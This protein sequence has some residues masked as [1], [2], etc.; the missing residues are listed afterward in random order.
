MSI[1][2]PT[3]NKDHLEFYM[4]YGISPVRQNI[5]DIQKHLERRSSLYRKIGA[6]SILFKDK[7]VLEVGPGSGHNSLYVASC[8]PGRYDLLEPNKTAQMGIK[9]L[10]S[11]IKLDLIKPNL[12]KQKLEDFSTDIEYDIVICE[13]WL[14]V[15]AHEREMMKKLGELV[16]QGGIL[17]TTIASPLGSVSNG[18]R[19]VLSWDIVRNIDNINKKQKIL[20]DAYSAHLDTMN[21]MS[22]VYEDWVID[23]LINPG[24]LTM[25]PQPDMFIDDIGGKFDIY[26]SFPKFYNDWRWYKSLYGKNK[27]FNEQF[28]NSYHRNIHNFF[29]YRNCHTQ[30][31]KELGREIEVESFNFISQIAR[32]EDNNDAIIDDKIFNSIQNIGLF[33]SNINDYWI[34]SFKEVAD[35]MESKSITK[36]DISKMKYFHKLFGRELIYVSAIKL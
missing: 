13:A 21:D 26:E 28:L 15:S 34:N 5:D 36:N 7:N 10:Y 31:S 33:M 19:R 4:E 17:I 23:T 3:T 8:K 2:I 18:I 6:P 1:E 35:L 11:T 25:C 27:L 22:R 32:K 30:I 29:D 12:I 20:L 24:F 16:S 9:E 14:G